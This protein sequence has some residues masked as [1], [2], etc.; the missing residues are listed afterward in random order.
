MQII[1]SVEPNEAKPRSSGA[2]LLSGPPQAARM[3]MWRCL[4]PTSSLHRSEDR[5]RIPTSC[6]KKRDATTEDSL[7]TNV[8]FVTDGAFKLQSAIIASL[9]FSIIYQMPKQLFMVMFS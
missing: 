2:T 8:T 9:S 5:P 1:V 3:R 7:M 4:T 6:G